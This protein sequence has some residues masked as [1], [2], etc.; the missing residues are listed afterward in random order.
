[1]TGKQTISDSLQERTKGGVEM[2]RKGRGWAN[3]VMGIKEGICC[4]EYW[5]L[6]VSD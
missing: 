3:W 5:V 2:E 6:Y 4:D 1:M